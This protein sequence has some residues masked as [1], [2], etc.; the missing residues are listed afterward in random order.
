[1]QTKTNAVFPGSVKCFSQGNTSRPAPGLR[2]LR[3]CEQD[4][5]LAV[6]RDWFQQRAWALPDGCDM[7]LLQKYLMR[8]G[9]GGALGALA[10]NGL[11]ADEQMDDWGRQHYYTNLLNNERGMVAARR[12]LAAAAKIR[13]PI[14]FLKGPALCQQA[15][16]DAGVRSYGDL[17]VFVRSDEDARRILAALDCNYNEEPCDGTFVDRLRDPGKL[18]AD[19]GGWPVEFCYPVD[20]FSSGQHAINSACDPMLDLLARHADRLLATPFDAE[21][22]PLPDPGLHFVFLL[23]HLAL[24][25]LF[26]RLVWFL[27]LAALQRQTA[28]GFSALVTTELAQLQ[29]RNVA[30]AAVDFC[31]Q[32]IDEKF[33]AFEPARRDASYRL[34]QRMTSAEAI[35]EQRLSFYPRKRW[36]RLA[37]R[38]FKIG[39]LW[40]LTD[41]A[42]GLPGR[43]TANRI[44][45]ALRLRNQGL[46]TTVA[47]AITCIRLLMLGVA[48]AAAELLLRRPD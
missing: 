24:N 45:Y 40:M 8:H 41:T 18:K 4:A 36:R 22:L 29:A 27:D 12:L 13:T 14:I 10:L 35:S 23:E 43:W 11:V 44:V 38:L 34:L 6:P 7:E 33:P 16:G 47:F 42:S 31:R 5:L 3:A 37:M 46:K 28:G 32:H 19:V 17:D 1:V 25:H 9:L 26:T 21:T 20:V 15:Y 48:R 30:A 2:R 39:T